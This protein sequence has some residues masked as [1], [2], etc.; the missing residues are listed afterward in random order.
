MAVTLAV[1]SEVLP[2]TSINFVKQ[3][4]FGKGMMMM[5]RIWISLTCYLVR[6]FFCPVYI[7][8]V[9]DKV[10]EISPEFP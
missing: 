2:I 10:S 5:E 9:P 8:L 6:N 4:C 1:A 7:I 3:P